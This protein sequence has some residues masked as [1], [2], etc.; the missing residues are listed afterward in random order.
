M[1]LW[2]TGTGWAVCL[3]SASSLSS[4]VATE[5]AESSIESLAPIETTRS[6]RQAFPQATEK[7]QDGNG[8]QR[9]SEDA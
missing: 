3:R 1:L 6:S 9:D 5:T 4:G 8:Q 2:L 7:A